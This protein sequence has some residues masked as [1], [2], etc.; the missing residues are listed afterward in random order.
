MIGVDSCPR[1]PRTPS[2]PPPYL[3]T[4]FYFK[5]SVWEG[6]AP[7]RWEGR[8]VALPGRTPT[9]VLGPG[10]NRQGHSLPAKMWN[11]GVDNPAGQFFCKLDRRQPG[12]GPHLPF[13]PWSLA[14]FECPG[15]NDGK[16]KL[17]LIF[18]FKKIEQLKGSGGWGGC[19]PEEK[20]VVR[21]N[22]S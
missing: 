6:R 12:L 19:V 11:R 3:A 15:R 14:C 10:G 13:E 16:L 21:I 9:L 8:W 17:L 18:S 1:F 20:V 4:L 22:Q 5:S 7:P 2:S